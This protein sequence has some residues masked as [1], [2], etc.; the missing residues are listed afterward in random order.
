MSVTRL[1]RRPRS[2]LPTRPVIVLWLNV[3]P[4]SRHKGVAGTKTYN[5]R[6]TTLAHNYEIVT[7]MAADVSTV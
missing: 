5:F 3:G 1:L 4:V 7:I 6:V 2:T